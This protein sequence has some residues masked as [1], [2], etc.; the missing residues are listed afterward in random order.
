MSVPM[1]LLFLEM[2]PVP[3]HFS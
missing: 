2:I 1:L 3:F